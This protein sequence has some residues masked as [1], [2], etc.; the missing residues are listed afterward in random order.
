MRHH[1]RGCHSVTAFGLLH[2]GAQR[3]SVQVVEV[4]MCNQ[5]QVNGRQI[6]HPQARLPQ[7]LEDEEPARKV[8]I[9]DNI[10]AANLEEETGMTDESYAHLAAG[11]QL[12]LV[13]VAGPG[14]DRGAPHQAAE[15]PGTVAESAILQG[16]F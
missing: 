9:D 4:G 8:G 11:R 1:N 14:S 7:T 5:H 2:D 15:L 3:R 6:A 12:G 10:L 13:G 16:V